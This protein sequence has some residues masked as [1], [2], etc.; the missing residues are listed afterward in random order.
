MSVFVLLFGAIGMVSVYAS[1]GPRGSTATVVAVLLCL[2]VI[3]VAI[4]MGRVHLGSVP[5]AGRNPWRRGPTLFIIYADVGVTLSV[6]TYSDSEYALFGTLLFAV[7]SAYASHFVPP[8]AT[9]IHVAF[10]SAVILAIGISMLR[11][12]LYD[13]PGTVARVATTLL[14]V[15][16][17]VV[18]HS[19]CTHEVRHAIAR[20]AASAITDPLTGIGNRRAFEQQ[21][22]RLISSGD[23]TVVVLLDIDGFKRI[24]DTSGHSGGDAALVQVAQALEVVLGPDAVVARLGGDEFAAALPAASAVVAEGL[25]EVLR[26]AVRGAAGLEVSVGVARVSTAVRSAENALA[27][28]LVVA[29]EHLYAQKR[30]QRVLQQHRSEP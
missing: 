24:N 27:E 17:T 26:A 6:L 23:E 14:A 7:V 19:L 4:A 22:V 12:G 9:G 29:D 21:A 8:L 13:V 30:L 15:N 28:A 1:G 2:T 11:S 18:L 3:P 10:T 16:G 25:A 5:W 20:S